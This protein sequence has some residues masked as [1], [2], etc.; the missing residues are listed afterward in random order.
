MAAKANKRQKKSELQG[1]QKKQKKISKNE[2]EIKEVEEE[3][4]DE[5]VEEIE[6]S[7][8]V[9]QESEEGEDSSN[10]S[11]NEEIT[12]FIEMGIDDRILLAVIEQGWAEP[13]PIQETAIPLILQGRDIL[14]KARTG[15]GKTGAYG[16]P[17]LHKILSMKKQRAKQV[18]T[19]LV[20]TP[21]RELCSQA[22]KNLHELMVYCQ[23]EISVVD[24]SS[25]QMSLQS[26]KQI[27]ATKS[28]II[29]S[30]PTKI[31]AHLKD[32]SS[33]LDLKNTLE[34]LV[35]D[36]ADLLLS[37]GYEEEM[38]ILVNYLPKNIQTVLLSATL[39]EE[40]QSVK[41]L[42]LHNP[43]ILKLKDSAELP[44]PVQLEQY[45]I[46]CNDEEDKFV[47]LYS[48]IKLQLI[49]GKSL[50][51]V[52]S[53]NRCYKLKLYLENFGIRSC[54]L[55]S[56]LPINSRMHIIEQFNGGIY[57]TIIASDE[58]LIEGNDDKN[59]VEN[60][61]KSK[62][63]KDKEYNIS[64][65]I[66]FRNVNNV[67]NFD[68]PLST[69]SYI[70]RVGRTARGKNQGTALSLVDQNEKDLLNQ[71]EEDL[72][73]SFKTR[74]STEAVVLF[75]P[76]KFKMDEIEG[77]RYRA[78]DVIRSITTIAI[79]EARIKE[80]K[81]ELLNSEKLKSYF[82]ENPREAQ[83]LRHDKE[84][85][86]TK[87]DEHLRNVPDYIIPPSLRGIQLKNLTNKKNKNK[88]K[89]RMTNSQKKYR[90]NKSDPLRSFNFAGLKK[91]NKKA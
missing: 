60:K 4:I 17:L 84:L 35:I 37:F 74:D 21:S 86:V 18:T 42:Y 85:N 51:F 89:K 1:K 30:T 25:S 62:K 87:L 12:S 73:E 90:A 16:I 33:A 2:E 11:D 61:Q 40:V 52:N 71:V 44:D 28:D 34:M 14:A 69:K 36:E 46:T 31:L 58:K 43:A 38:K 19:A 75:K 55:N 5:P 24:I 82:E 78:R 68:F 65:G 15:S 29:V 59:N 13:T 27:L 67:I 45:Q 76:F 83:I 49:K 64:R 48:I 7:Q 39:N 81:N 72:K 20:L 56:E 54:V 53:V 91:K 70:H 26:Q 63:K 57:D 66:D 6:E 8:I 10:E 9:S 80:I 22:C 3:K 50:I 47:L 79:K 77:F 88:N 32:D 41:S 23:R